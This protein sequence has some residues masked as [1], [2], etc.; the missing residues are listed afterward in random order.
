M[1]KGCW[2]LGLHDGRSRWGGNQGLGG[3]G[4]W[5][6]WTRI[7]RGWGWRGFLIEGGR[8]GI[9]YYLPRRNLMKGLSWRLKICC[10]LMERLEDK[11]SGDGRRAKRD[12]RRG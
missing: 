12:V 2:S 7:G 10:R 11:G 3:G 6:G 1:S 5:G 9:H 4:G 8:F